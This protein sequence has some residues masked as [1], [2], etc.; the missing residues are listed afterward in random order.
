MP[1]VLVVDDSA[2]DRRLVG[3]L[4]KDDD[5]LDLQFAADGA[6]AMAQIE[7]AIPDLVITDLVM[8]QVNGLELL[9]ALRNKFPLVPV[10]L[11]TSRGSEEVAVRAL[12]QGAAS[13]VPK[14]RL[15]W[16]LLDTVRGVLAVSSRERS[17]T[18]LM[19]CMT[20]SDSSFALEND[21]ALF[22]PLVVY[23]QEQIARMGL[24][25]QAE[26]VRVGV[27]LEEALT[28]ALYHGNLRVDPRLR[29]ED[30][31]AYHALVEKRRRE[32][33][34]CD[35]RIHV[36]ATLSRQEAR[37]VVRDEGPGFDPHALPDPTQPP[38]L[39]KASGRGVLL[40]RT[41]M[42]KIVYNRA[43]NAVTLIKRR[44]S[45]APT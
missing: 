1:T 24:C 16:E 19:D 18:R 40:M 13:Y 10:I 22:G 27:S 29:E 38:H 43:G 12:K 26:R 31:Q 23:L 21:S 7:R 36:R 6:E 34:Y 8:P 28:N 30:S 17:Q 35:R 4:L 25:D 3:E 45:S 2:G 37:F 20:R 14:H 32:K 15:A 41:L 39:E 44:D 33:P 9:A 11:T 42:D 5:N